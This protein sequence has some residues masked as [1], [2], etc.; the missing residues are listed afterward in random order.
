MRE[1]ECDGLA[2]DEHEAEPTVGKHAS[3]LQNGEEVLDVEGEL[4]RRRGEDRVDRCTQRR[5]SSPHTS[6]PQAVH[7]KVGWALVVSSE[8]LHG[9]SHL[10]QQNLLVEL[11]GGAGAALDV[12]RGAL[13]HVG[14][15]RGARMPSLVAERPS[16]VATDDLARHAP[17][18]RLVAAR[19]DASGE[20]RQLAVG[21]PE[22]LSGVALGTECAHPLDG[23]PC[24]E[25]FEEEAGQPVG[26]ASLCCCD[27]GVMYG[28]GS[29]LCVT[30][31][32]ALI[33]AN[34]KS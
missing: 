12:V 34:S 6:C 7:G 8:H 18:E 31:I 30:Y 15:I 33:R 28:G 32:H 4:H 1:V 17:T 27:F 26:Q 11:T 14:P 24:G 3:I 10:D 13:P 22:G 2:G 19:V 29:C 5:G 16:A 25:V 23:V 9:L 20:P 21:D